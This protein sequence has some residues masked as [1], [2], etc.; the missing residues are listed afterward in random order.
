VRTNLVPFQLI[1]AMYQTQMLR[2]R[3]DCMAFGM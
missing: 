1:G 3:R 2:P